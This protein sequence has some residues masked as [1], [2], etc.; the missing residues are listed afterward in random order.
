MAKA[1][2]HFAKKKINPNEKEIYAI[3]FVQCTKPN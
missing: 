2:L 1:N 3:F